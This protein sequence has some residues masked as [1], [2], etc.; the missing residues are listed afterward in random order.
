M[1]RSPLRNCPSTSTIPIANKLRPCWTIA[2]R[3]PASTVIRPHGWAEKPI[4]R[5][6]GLIDLPCARNSVPTC[7]PRTIRTSTPGCRPL[8]IITFSPAV[9][10]IRA[11]F[12]LLA[13][14]AG[15]KPD[16]PIH[17]HRTC[18]DSS[19]S[20]TVGMTRDLLILRIA[21]IEPLDIRQDDQQRSSQQIGHQSGQTIIVAKRGH[22]FVDRHRVVFVNDR[23][24]LEIEQCPQRVAHVKISRAIVHIVGRQQYL[25]RRSTVLAKCAV[26]SFDQS[27]LADRRHGLQP[28]H[29]L[30]PFGPAPT[31]SSPLPPPRN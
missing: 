7:S 30:R 3:A 11:A 21:V 29:I 16:L 15:A 24:G 27:G 1:T 28:G 9:V 25:G 6:R 26:V 5:F 12:S 17:A 18:T 31:G 4:H 22:Q 2:A 19:N 20:L 8:A 13:M 23:H 10:A 14:P